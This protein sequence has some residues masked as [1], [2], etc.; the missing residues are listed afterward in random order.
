MSAA[1][2]ATRAWILWH[3]KTAVPNCFRSQT[4]RNAASKA[5]RTTS[6]GAAYR[7]RSRWRPLVRTLSPRF[8]PPRNF[9]AG[10]SQPTK[11]GSAV[12]EPRRPLLV[13]VRPRLN[14]GKSFSTVKAGIPSNPVAGSAMARKVSTG[15]RSSSSVFSWIQGTPSV[16]AK[17]TTVCLRQPCL[18][19]GSKSM[20]PFIP[21][22]SERG[23]GRAADLRAS[24]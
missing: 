20:A 9:E 7:T 18:S 17:R 21:R 13:N 3:P 12:G 2:S 23:E 24:V 19:V 15:N 1:I 11:T 16:S 10:T 5:P 22:G 14:P 6:T 4:Y 8:S